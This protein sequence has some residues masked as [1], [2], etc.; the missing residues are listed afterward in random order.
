MQENLIYYL[1]SHSTPFLDN[2]FNLITMIGEPHFIIFITTIVFWNISKKK[3]ILLSFIFIISAVSND[4]LKLTFQTKRP[5][6]ELDGITGKRIQTAT[7]YSFPSGHTQSSTSFF[8]T[9]AIMIKKKKFLIFALSI[10]VLVGFSRLYL[11]VHW[12][13]DIAGALV[14]GYLIANF[15]FKYL[16]K[17]YDDRRKFIKFTIILSSFIIITGLLLTILNDFYLEGELYLNNYYKIAGAAIGI[18]SGYLLQEKYFPFT[19]NHSLSIK[20]WRYLIGIS[21]VSILM[22]GLKLIFPTTIIFDSTRY[23]IV[24]T[25]ITFIYPAIGIKLKLFNSEQG[26]VKKN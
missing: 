12:L 8:I 14:F 26:S 17:I 19:T 16:D 18:L 2:L 1:Q 3:G 21:T 15:V 10:S 7:G 9:S 23:F 25:Y 6:Q 20:I 4:L 11:G 13:I 5:F 22:C 24:G